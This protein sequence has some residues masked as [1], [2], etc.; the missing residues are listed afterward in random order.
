MLQAAVPIA[1][2]QASESQNREALELPPGG[3]AERLADI[4]SNGGLNQ[5]CSTCLEQHRESGVGKKNGRRQISTRRQ[6]APDTRPLG[7]SVRSPLPS[8]SAGAADLEQLVSQIG[9]GRGP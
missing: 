2:C 6:T 3:N 7:N 9:L 8:Q 4:G 1:A 5:A